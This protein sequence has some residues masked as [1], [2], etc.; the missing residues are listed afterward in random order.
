MGSLG[1]CLHQDCHAIGDIANISPRVPSTCKQNAILS[2]LVVYIIPSHQ[3]YV[4]VDNPSFVPSLWCLTTSLYLWNYICAADDVS[5]TQ[6]LQ[7]NGYQCF[8][9]MY[10]LRVGIQ[11]TRVFRYRSER[12][13][14]PVLHETSILIIEL[15]FEYSLQLPQETPIQHALTPPLP[16]AVALPTPCRSGNLLHTSSGFLCINTSVMCIHPPNPQL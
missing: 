3:I 15:D 10:K 1:R 11:V 5:C 12:Q 4:V 16:P 13:G 2:F 7:S 14:K 6:N 9:H 8:L